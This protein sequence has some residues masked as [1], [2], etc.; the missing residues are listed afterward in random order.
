MSLSEP[1]FERI[2]IENLATLRVYFGL[3][4]SKL[5]K[6]QQILSPAAQLLVLRYKNCHPIVIFTYPNIVL[7]IFVT[8]IEF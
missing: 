5:P 3:K 4:A 7:T 2:K 6:T 8:F 1:L